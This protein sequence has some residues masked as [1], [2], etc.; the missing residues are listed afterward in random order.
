MAQK[1]TRKKTN[2]RSNKKNANT[3]VKIVVILL[4]LL[5]LCVIILSAIFFAISVVNN[6]A[7]TTS[8]PNDT[9]PQMQRFPI[10][11]IN[12]S[13]QVFSNSIYDQIKQIT[14]ITSDRQIKVR[15]ELPSI[16]LT[17]DGKTIEKIDIALNVYPD[18]NSTSCY[19]AK[20]I[21]TK[22]TDKFEFLLGNTLESISTSIELKKNALT[23]TLKHI[24]DTMQTMDV[25]IFAPASNLY[26]LEIAFVDDWLNQN[27]IDTISSLSGSKKVTFNDSIILSQ[28]TK[29]E[30]DQVD[31]KTNVVVYQLKTSPNADALPVICLLDAL[32]S[33][34]QSSS[35][36]EST[37]TPEEIT[38]TQLMD[39]FV[40]A[41]KE[42]NAN[43]IKH[44]LNFDT[45]GHFSELETVQFNDISFELQNDTPSIK[46]YA[47]IVDVLTSNSSIFTKGKNEWVVTIAYTPSTKSSVI[48]DIEKKASQSTK[49]DPLTSLIATVVSF[50]VTNF[51]TTA[52]I[53]PAN[54]V[55]ICMALIQANKHE[56]G[57]T[58]VWDFTLE[59]VNQTVQTYFGISDFDGTNLPSYD[60]ANGTY[61]ILGKGLVAYEQEVLEK[62]WDDATQTYAIKMKFFSSNI[63]NATSTLFV[64]SV[65]KKNTDGTHT[66]ISMQSS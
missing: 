28:G 22:E 31:E 20:F 57:E 1:P 11:T 14:G 64:D 26:L 62:K 10:S 19:P 15:D 38:P 29:I 7:S 6:G 46:T 34:S 9:T 27:T 54:L 50:G 25:T 4:S 55:D 2:T 40:T 21:Y 13:N 16:A 59:E 45:T 44:L 3:G 8:K 35:S 49:K 61:F 17:Q 65:V 60:Q 5:I 47:L 63:A 66:I 51:S 58:E 24:F 42:G 37:D 18:G 39:Q 41:L 33:P 43:T 36:S 32:K 12:Q 53:S 30:K 23:L 48:T 56:Q 52:E